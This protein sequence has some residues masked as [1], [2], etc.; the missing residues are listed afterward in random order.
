MTEFPIKAV[1]DFKGLVRP[2]LLVS[3]VELDVR[4]FGRPH[5]T[6]GVYIITKQTDNISMA[7]YK[8]TLEL[9]RIGGVSQKQRSS[10][11]GS[12]R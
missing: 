1:I 9:Q 2:T 7:G 4:F 8:T 3:Y 6:S 10:G 12:G 11:G 5:V